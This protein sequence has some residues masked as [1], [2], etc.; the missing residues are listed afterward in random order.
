MADVNLNLV[1]KGVTN[2]TDAI[3]QFGKKAESALS[4]VKN[5]AAGLVIGTA[6]VKGLEKSIEAAI[7]SEK[8]VIKLNNSLRLTGDFTEETSKA[9]EQ[10][11]GNIEKQLR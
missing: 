7:E 10:F 3:S 1:L 2:A 8:A 4:N 9:F 5:I 11:A 6:F